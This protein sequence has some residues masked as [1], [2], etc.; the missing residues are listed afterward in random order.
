MGIDL[1]FNQL[2]YDGSFK[3]TPPDDYEFLELNS[4]KSVN[5]NIN[6]FSHDFEIHKRYVMFTTGIGL[7]LQNYHFNS[8]KVL[9]SD[10]NRVYS[11]FR[12]MDSGERIYFSKSKLAV[13]YVTLPI[14]LQFNTR[15]DYNHSFHIGTGVLIHYKYNSHTKT[16]YSENGDKVKDKDHDEFNISPFRAD[17]TLRMGYKWFTVYASYGLTEF[18][19]DDRGPEAHPFNFG[20]HFGI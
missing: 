20:L 8:D 9:V 1:G 11:D 18:F 19:K 7:T 2:M 12:Y 15:P 16:V 4:G 6:I 10:T 3:S 13:N 5:V 17:L 14:L